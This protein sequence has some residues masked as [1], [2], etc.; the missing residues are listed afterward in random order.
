MG[1]K[2]EWL[3]VVTDTNNQQDDM[4]PYMTTMVDGDNLAFVYNTSQANP[5]Q[6]CEEDPLCVVRLAVELY[7]TQFSVVLEEELEIYYK[8]SEEEWDDLKP[9]RAQRSEAIV[10]KIRTSKLMNIAPSPPLQEAVSG[11]QSCDSCTS[12][13]AQAVEVM[14]V[15]RFELLQSARWLPQSGLAIYDSLFPH[16]TGGFRGRMIKVTSIDYPPWQKLEEVGGK[17]VGHSGLMF[18]ILDELSHRLNFTYEV[19]TPTDGMWGVRDRNGRFNGMMQ[20]LINKEVLVGCAAFTV[21]DVRKKYVDFSAVVDK[22][23]Y[24]FMIARP[25]ELSRVILFMEPFSNQTWILIAVTVLL[26]GPILYLINNNSPYYDYYSLKDG[27]G[28]FSLQNC[29]WYVFGAILQ[30][31]GTKL[32]LSHSGRLVVGF[33]WVFVLI[34]VTTY[35]GNLVAFLTFPKVENAVQTLDDLLAAKG[36]MTW[37]YLRGT[38][39]KEYF[40]VREHLNFEVRERR[41]FGVRENLNFEESEGKFAEIGELAEV[42]TSE[43]DDLFQRVKFSDHAYIQWKT[44]LLVTMKNEFLRTDSC[45][46]SLGREE[47]FPEHVAMAVPKGSPHLWKFDEEIKLMLKGGLVQKWMQDHWPKKDRCS[48]TAYGS[49][50]GTRTVSL[51]DMQGS[52][53]LLGLGFILALVFMMGE[54]IVRWKRTRSQGSQATDGKKAAFSSTPVAFLFP[55]ETKEYYSTMISK[56]SAT[57]PWNRYRYRPLE[58]LPLPS[59]GTATATVPWNRYRPSVKRSMIPKV[60][61]TVPW[62]RYRYRPLEPLPLPSPGTA[63]ATVPWNR[64]RYRPLEPLPLPSPGTATATKSGVDQVFAALQ[65]ENNCHRRRKCAREVVDKR[66]DMKERAVGL[67]T[68]QLLLASLVAAQ[69][70]SVNI[71][72]LYDAENAAAAAGI[73]AAVKYFTDTPAERIVVAAHY[74]KAIVRGAVGWCC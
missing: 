44:N 11:R 54:F 5:T 55:S 59:L 56:V 19:V 51:S 28:L 66:P 3:F 70:T 26:M 7:A 25:Q 64:Y 46:F 8:V 40:Q 65:F 34:V 35:S 6:P 49:G 50:D 33:W 23:P 20:Q 71:M 4:S 57:V 73:T 15:D 27:R 31:G 63:T 53:I 9:T 72:S 69:T 16:V 1:S 14:D 18:D 45:D 62:N 24:T 61:A 48:T 21:T 2:H 13:A 37:G 43:D 41:N 58:P 10:S 22:Q 42:H 47:F 38:A 52:F 60:S 32:P 36:S 30:Q 68:S 12:W 39:L 67:V 17:V 29:S 74:S